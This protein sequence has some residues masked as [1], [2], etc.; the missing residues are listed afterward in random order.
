MNGLDTRVS[1]ASGVL[2]FKTF[3]L[4]VHPCVLATFDLHAAKRFG[5]ASWALLTSDI[6]ELSNLIKSIQREMCFFLVFIEMLDNSYKYPSD[7]VNVLTIQNRIT[8][9]TSLTSL[10]TRTQLAQPKIKGL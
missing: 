8:F 4:I 3:S 2:Y 5:Q 6:K 10:V 1:I 9:L 7:A